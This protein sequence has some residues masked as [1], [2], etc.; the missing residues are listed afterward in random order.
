VVR[1]MA[2]AKRMHGI[3]PYH[4]G[5]IVLMAKALVKDLLRATVGHSGSRYIVDSY[6]RLTGRSAIWTKMQ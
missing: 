3:F 5:W 6:R 2:R 1:E 4:L